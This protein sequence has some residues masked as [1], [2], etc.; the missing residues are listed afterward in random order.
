MTIIN[1]VT[2]LLPRLHDYRSTIAPF[3]VLVCG[4]LLF[5]WISQGTQLHQLAIGIAMAA[6]TLTVTLV[7]FEL[8]WRVGMFAVTLFDSQ[9]RN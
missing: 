3:A 7:L 5:L 9:K 4:A 2:S 6:I 8:C 1:E